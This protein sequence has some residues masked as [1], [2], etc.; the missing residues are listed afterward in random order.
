MYASLLKDTVAA[1]LRDDVQN[2]G[3]E[4]AAVVFSK[5]RRANVGSGGMSVLSSASSS[6]SLSELPQLALNIMTTLASVL[7]LDVRARR[8]EEEAEQAAPVCS[9]EAVATSE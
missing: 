3:C 5:G 4:E 2:G 8:E 7:L 6:S 9:V 1:S